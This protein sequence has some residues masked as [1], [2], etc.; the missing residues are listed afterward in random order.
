MLA[1]HEG[2]RHDRVE[3]A[4]A[5]VGHGVHERGEREAKRG[6]DRVDVGGASLGEG[7][8][9]AGSDGHEGGRAKELGNWG[10]GEEEEARG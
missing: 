8:G 2:D 9:G 7:R 6:P 3:L 5:R 1:E 10:G 4:R